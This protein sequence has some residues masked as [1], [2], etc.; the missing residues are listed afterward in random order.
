EEETHPFPLKG[1]RMHGRGARELGMQQAGIVGRQ[2]LRLRSERCEQQQRKGPHQGSRRD[3]G[4]GFDE[5]RATKVREITSCQLSPWG[6][7]K[8]Q[9]KPSPSEPSDTMS[10][11]PR[12]RQAAASAGPSAPAMRSPRQRKPIVAPPQWAHSSRYSAASKAGT[13]AQSGSQWRSA[14]GARARS[15]RPR[16]IQQTRANSALAKSTNAASMAA[17]NIRSPRRARAEA[18]RGSEGNAA[19]AMGSGNWRYFSASGAR[20]SG[21]KRAAGS[22]FRLAGAGAGAG[23]DVGADAAM[24]GS[25]NGA[26]GSRSAAAAGRSWGTGA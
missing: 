12:R 20:K 24:R 25:G 3:D 10:A 1:H 16:A 5:S 19:A 6:S 4:S 11:H 26:K 22:S 18:R 21:R 13:T 7:Q 23:A 15:G 8:I 14:R 2:R 17:A 9:A